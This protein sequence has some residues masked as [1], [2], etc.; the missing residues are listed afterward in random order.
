M[1]RAARY[2]AIAARLMREATD[3]TIT[4]SR[5]QAAADLATYYAR[6]AAHYARH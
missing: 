5:R 4:A 3:S 1:A 2:G 6:R